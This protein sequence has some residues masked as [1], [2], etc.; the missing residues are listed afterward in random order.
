MDNLFDF[1]ETTIENPDDFFKHLFLD[2]CKSTDDDFDSI[3]SFK[4]FIKAFIQDNNFKAIKEGFDYIFKNK[5]VERLSVLVDLNCIDNDNKTKALKILA[6]TNKPI[7]SLITDSNVADVIVSLFNGNRETEAF[8]LIH[9]YEIKKIDISSLDKNVL[10]NLLIM[11]LNDFSFIHIFTLLF[12]SCSEPTELLFDFINTYNEELR[13]VDY[14][15]TIQKESLKQFIPQIKKRISKDLPGVKENVEVYELI[16]KTLNI[17]FLD[18]DDYKLAY[19]CISNSNQ[20]A[21]SMLA[22]NNYFNEFTIPKVIPACIHF[23]KPKLFGY[24]LNTYSYLNKNLIDNLK[25]LQKYKFEYLAKNN[26]PLNLQEEFI[27]KDS[28]GVISYLINN[29]VIHKDF[30]ITYLD[31][32]FKYL[33]ENEAN[34]SF[35]ADF[36]TLFFANK[37]YV[38]TIIDFYNGKIDINYYFV[39]DYFYFNNDWDF[40]KNHIN[41]PFHFNKNMGIYSENNLSKPLDS[42]YIDFMYDTYFKDKDVKEFK[43]FIRSLAIG[44]YSLFHKF[45]G[46]LYKQSFD[47]LI[48]SYNKKF[49]EHIKEFGF[50]DLATDLAFDPYRNNLNKQTKDDLDFFKT[51]LFSDLKNMDMDFYDT[52]M[53]KRANL[54][55]LLYLSL[56][57]IN[58]KLNMELLLATIANIKH[59]NLKPT[60]EISCILTQPLLKEK[61]N[62]I[63]DQVFCV[64][65]FKILWDEGLIGPEN[66]V[67]QSFDLT[68]NNHLLYEFLMSKNIYKHLEKQNKNLINEFL[69]FEENPKKYL[70]IPY[71]TVKVVEQPKTNNKEPKL[72]TQLQTQEE[73][74]FDFMKKDTKN[75]T[76]FVSRLFSTSIPFWIIGGIVIIVMLKL[77]FIS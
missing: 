40:I 23:N 19:D 55:V 73:V 7:N 72:Q 11:S 61:H 64:D 13:L 67:Q 37:I 65:A 30:L 4:E 31:Y 51:R 21:L 62:D 57:G 47:N 2:T 3:D 38:P 1:N 12:N 20:K 29:T 44:R 69:K 75:N 32:T 28:F 16:I 35:L 56:I 14:F 49:P 52:L 46:G 45:F 26:K 59:Q 22:D 43:L 6:N 17:Q 74:D 77:K 76:G 15:L 50:S 70:T 33:K 34:L 41:Q 36:I 63:I 25:Y 39:V 5:N 24:F 68:V 60:F 27:K 18:N 42:N 54:F 71:S 48:T 9:K 58:Y 66:I 8:D 10:N 53:K